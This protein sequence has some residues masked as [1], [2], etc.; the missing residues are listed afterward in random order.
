M[1]EKIVGAMIGAFGGLTSIANG[2]D[3]L[4]FII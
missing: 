2:K 4:V 3:I 1:S